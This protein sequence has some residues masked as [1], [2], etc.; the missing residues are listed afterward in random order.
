MEK[1]KTKEEIE[2]EKKL[3]E[4]FQKKLAELKKRDPFIYKNF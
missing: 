1:K 3:E 4:E 2:K